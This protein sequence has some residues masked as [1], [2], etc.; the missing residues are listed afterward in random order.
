MERNHTSER[1]FK[2]CTDDL[3]SFRI[4]II[5]LSLY[6]VLKLDLSWNGN[7]QSHL[8]V[9]IYVQRRVSSKTICVYT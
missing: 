2:L 6:R 3:R 1:M 8:F 4:S 9:H 5:S 7:V